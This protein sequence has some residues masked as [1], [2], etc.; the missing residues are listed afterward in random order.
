MLAQ[1]GGL[2]RVGG[3][4]IA[5]S[6]ADVAA[7]AFDFDGELLPDIP[8]LLNSERD[9]IHLTIG[10]AGTTF[11]SD[12]GAPESESLGGA[13]PGGIDESAEVGAT[14]AQTNA[15]PSAGSGALASAGSLGSTEEASFPVP[16]EFGGPGGGQDLTGPGE[17]MTGGYGTGGAGDVAL[18]PG[19]EVLRRSPETSS[20]S[21]LRAMAGRYEEI[22]D[23]DAADRMGSAN[24]VLALGALLFLVTLL[25]GPLA[26]VVPSRDE[27]ALD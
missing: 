15:D 21:P 10:A 16:S 4:R 6:R 9:I 23:P 12:L 5:E 18:A 26:R 25:A 13:D 14:D 11:F 17:A 24:A 20:G 7:L 1:R 3:F 27:D 19:P 8:G 22:A 2:V